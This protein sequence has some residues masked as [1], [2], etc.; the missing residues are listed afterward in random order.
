[1]GWK[2][3]SIMEI[4]KEFIDKAESEGMTEA[5]RQ[6]EISRTVGY[7][8]V[9]RFQ[10]GGYEALADQSRAPK[11]IPHKT[12]EEIAAR[13]VAVKRRYKSWG[14]KK[15]LAHVRR[16]FPDESWPAASTVGE[17]LGRAGE[18]DH[19][20]PSRGRV[21]PWTEPLRHAQA[22]N[23][24]WSIDFK[25]QFM[26]GNGALCYPLTITDNFS[27]ELL[28]CHA[29]AGTAGEPVRQFMEKVFI[30]KGLPV[31][32]RSDNGA[33][34]ASCGPLGLSA[35]SAWWLSL[36]ITHER[37][38]VGHP[39]QNGRHERMHLTLKQETARPGGADFAEQQ[40]RFDDFQHTFN[41][42][43]PHEALGMA[44]P[45]DLYVPSSRAY[46]PK[47]VRLDYREC[48]LKRAVRHSGEIK[49]GRN[50]VYVGM[51]FAHFDVGLL[52]VDE[53]VW[54]VRFAGHDLGYFE[55]G[56][57]KMEPIERGRAAQGQDSD[58]GDD[59][60]GGASAQS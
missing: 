57:N 12:A 50:H 5:C 19:V 25:G 21:P 46:D 13:L 42:I 22:P 8:W 43:R 49:F 34:F 59:K 37:I 60:L 44:V 14:P 9:R 1:M 23:V 15:V 29:L 51:A 33:P 39:E 2:R 20:K 47:E 4:R 30:E 58:D 38:D 54:L 26:L 32:I 53:D 7:K 27:R 35:L 52:E 6:F 55:T 18:V 10:A 41:H 11:R 31:A 48:D 16:M 28:G 24:L 36:G 45:A 40:R 56:E 17:I 3:C